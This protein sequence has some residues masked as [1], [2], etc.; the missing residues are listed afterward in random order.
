MLHTSQLPIGRRNI[1][2]EVRILASG[3]VVGDRQRAAH[4]RIRSQSTLFVSQSASTSFVYSRI[5]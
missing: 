4:F 2:L 1:A 3:F 5:A